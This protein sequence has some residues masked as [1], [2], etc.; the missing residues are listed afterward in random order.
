[1]MVPILTA[2]PVLIVTF[3]NA[4][5]VSACLHALSR[6][7][8]TESFAVFIC[9][10]GG[11]DAFECLVA[12]LTGPQGRC[13]PDSALPML[14]SP[15]LSR[16]TR[17]RLRTSDPSRPIS[18]HVGE[19]SDNLGYAGGVNAYLEQLLK[20]PGWTG[21]WILNPDT[22]PSPDALNELVNYAVRHNRGMVGSLLVQRDQPDFVQSRGLVWRKWRAS[23]MAVDWWSSATACPPPDEVD[24]R[25]DAASGASVYVTRD[26]LARTGLMDE[27]YF[28]YFEDLDWGL[29]AKRH[30]AI[31]Y[32]H[33][34]V[35]MH[36]GGTTIGSAQ[37]RC[38]H[39]ALAVFL[40][41]RN[42]ILFVRRHFP[43]WL[44]WTILIE[45][46]ETLE[47]AR[48]RTFRNVLAAARGMGAGL[49]GRVGRPDKII[50]AH[51]LPAPTR[52]HPD[53]ER[54]SHPRAHR[55][56]IKRH[57]KIAISLCVFAALLVARTARRMVGAR[58]ER[59]LT[60]LYYHGIPPD[61]VAR[62]AQ[63]MRQL[64]RC[65]RV[66]PADWQGDAPDQPPTD[67]HIV[68][69]TFD[70]SFDSALD[71]ALPVL[72]GHGFH[73][74]IFVPTGNLGRPPSWAMEPDT[75]RG[76][77]VATAERLSQ[78]ASDLV[79]IGSHTITH[80]YLTSLPRQA[81]RQELVNSMN[82]L[83]RLTGG[84]VRLFAFP[85][86][87]HDA[88][89]VEMC[90]SCGYER[91]FTIDPTPVVLS[92]KAFTR[93]RVVADPT[94][95]MLEFFLKATGCYCWMST[96]TLIKRKLL[97]VFGAAKPAWYVAHS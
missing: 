33:R 92:K 39:S 72:A 21:V 22:E 58:W 5:D 96:G 41:F 91:V 61:R 46:V 83:K 3:R 31:G 29:R 48:L 44:P 16:V 93:G 52:K 56:A 85:Y 7:E 78:L 47:Y 26:C 55:D 15:R 27:R 17:L 97:R 88:A 74:T 35:V 11:P 8:P 1:M 89:S 60:I 49:L 34:S 75:D 51:Q 28:L 19:A 25:L 53:R 70:D 63:Q 36:E 32:A 24:R 50:D 54:S 9:E 37:S 40:D 13:D 23:T 30:S 66:V 42:R 59:S 57:A 80:P 77:R 2:I 81:A 65:A 71:N 86:G 84:S 45:A 95:G 67:R 20:H 62:F 12:S 69:I 43:S 4:A 87:D 38:R 73:C 6:M 10:N 64:A 82:T 79:T 94:D 18:V 90:R 76:E 14:T 68:A